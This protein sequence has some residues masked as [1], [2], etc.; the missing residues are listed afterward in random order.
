MNKYINI[1]FYSNFEYPPKLYIDWFYMKPNLRRSYKDSKR[2][3]L[4]FGV[5]SKYLTIEITWD[6]VEREMTKDEKDMKIKIDELF[7]ESR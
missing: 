2:F 1:S 3:V 7:K 4:S 6:F 5:F